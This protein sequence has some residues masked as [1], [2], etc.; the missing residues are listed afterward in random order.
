MFKTLGFILWEWVAVRGVY[1]GDGSMQVRVSESEV[2][3]VV[4]SKEGRCLLE[5]TEIS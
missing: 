2:W 1:A 3:Y 5:G 4:D